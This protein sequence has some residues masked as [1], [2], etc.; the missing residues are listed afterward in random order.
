NAAANAKLQ[1]IIEIKDQIG[2]KK[3]SIGEKKQDLVGKQG[4]EKDDIL[5]KIADDRADVEMKRKVLEQKRHELD[6]LKK[7]ANWKPQENIETPSRTIKPRTIK[8]RTIIKPRTFEPRTFEPRT[9]KP[10]NFEPRT[11]VKKA[12]P[13]DKANFQ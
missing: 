12:D 13:A 6:I 8:P 5:K 3:E 4:K 7:D 9:I 2:L 11:P 1:E 10:R